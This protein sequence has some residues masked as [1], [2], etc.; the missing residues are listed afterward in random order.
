MRGTKSFAIRVVTKLL[1]YLTKAV[2]RIVVAIGYFS[3]YLTL[4]M[5]LAVVYDVV[6]RFLFNRPTMWA[7][8]LVR[9]LLICITLLLAAWVL[10]EEGHIQVDIVVR[11]FKPRTQA[12]L[13][14][15]TGILI[16][17]T[18]AIF[19]WQCA[20]STLADY[21]SGIMT[22]YTLDIPRV[23]LMGVIAVGSFLLLF[24]SVRRFQLHLSQ[25][26]GLWFT[27]DRKSEDHS[28]KRTSP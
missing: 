17:A 3:S 1:I 23:V 11:L 26:I 6:L 2:D 12:L 18:C 25:F 16:M 20:K 4:V 28:L 15:I 21:Q 14:C 24:Q 27:Q 8:D 22:G 7:N 9:Y 5:V 13:S 10:R 19:S